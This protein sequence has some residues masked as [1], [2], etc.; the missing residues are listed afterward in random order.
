MDDNLAPSMAADA[1]AGGPSTLDPAHEPQSTEIDLHQALDQARELATRHQQV[2]DAQTQAR[3]RL[4]LMLIGLLILLALAVGVSS[5]AIHQARLATEQTQ[6]ARARQLAA[7]VSLLP[8]TA[9]DQ[10]LLLALE[11][12]RLDNTPESQSSL[13]AAT[14]RFADQAL[15]SWRGH[16]DHVWGA[17]FSPDGK[18]VASGSSDG[19]VILWDVAQRQPIKRLEGIHPGLGILRVAFSPGGEL[20]AAGTSDGAILLWDVASRRFLRTLN[21]HRASV[22]NLAFNRDGNRLVSGSADRRVI[23][24]DVAKGRPIFTGQHNDWV[25]DV[26]FSPDSRTVASVSRD[27]TVRLWSLDSA[28]GITQTVILTDHQ[29]AVTSLAFLPSLTTP[30]LVTGD[31]AGNLAFWDLSRWQTAHQKPTLNLLMPIYPGAIIWALDFSPDGARLVTAH[32]AG[33]QGPGLR[34]WDVELAYGVANVRLKAASLE[35]KGPADDVTDV[36]FSPNGAL[37]VASSLDGTVTLWQAG[38]GNALISQQGAVQSLALGPA[39]Q[40]LL[41]SSANGTVTRWNVVT[42]QAQL[43]PRLDRTAN[44]AFAVTKLNAD[45]SRLATGSSDGQ[46]MLWDV[47][48]C[49]IHGAPLAGHTA[50]VT[51]LVFN[52]TGTLLASGD[53][54]GQLILWPVAELH[55]VGDA[56][57]DQV[58]AID[59]LAFS[60]DGQ[61]LAAASCRNRFSSALDAA[62]E[63]SQIRL[64]DV[65]TRQ[66]RGNVLAAKSGNVTSLAFSPDAQSLAVASS[67]GS[68]DVWDVS[69]QQWLYGDNKP[70]DPVRSVIFSRDGAWLAAGYSDG[71]D[72]EWAG[73][74]VLWDVKRRAPFGRAF[75]EP[76]R[77]VTALLFSPDGKT[78]YVAGEDGVI[79]VHDLHSEQW[80]VR[81][82]QLANRNLT[83][84]E[85]QQEM[86]NT[87]YHK[88]CPALP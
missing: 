15:A 6:H 68:V 39:E 87:P 25:W 5:Y 54:A 72:D 50:A 36:A 63:R 88:S 47:A 9:S 8:T 74:V 19:S 13:L 43:Q 76:E 73:R 60:A 16:T 57:S 56:L 51:R 42:H 2:A 61:L 69:T 21:G 46:V 84:A 22:L 3:N 14:Q 86:G 29:S 38:A 7:Q 64:W 27:Q 52:P 23:V 1:P 10:A 48:G 67:N 80:R 24:W 12:N 34:F 11:A 77:V 53:R 65:A 33:K 28:S 82:C 17:A 78:L 83:L 4:R 18:V 32:G 71:Q 59:S 37:A 70:R 55:P 26:A 85:W 44:K 66:P 58:E 49:H 45:G 31:G 41:A 81:A 75:N 20:L 40:T 62:C 35:I 30:M 79:V